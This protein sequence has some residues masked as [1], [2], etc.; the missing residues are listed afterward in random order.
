[1]LHRSLFILSAVALFACNEG[2]AVDTRCND[3]RRTITLT[4]E[5]RYSGDAYE[6]FNATDY[7]GVVEIDS[8]E[9][10]IPNKRSIGNALSVRVPDPVQPYVEGSS[11]W[12]RPL[13]GAPMQLTGRFSLPGYLC[14]EATMYPNADFDAPS[15]I[16]VNSQCAPF[17]A[18]LE[19]IGAE[20]A[21]RVLSGVD[22]VEDVLPL[23]IDTLT[24]PELYGTTAWRSFFSG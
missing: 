5:L 16:G 9:L 2:N 15:V 1:M 13:H 23:E 24:T 14:V 11:V 18:N 20:E 19:T 22:V 3:C 17:P 12:E 7:A 10:A 6:L 8:S 21:A 4:V